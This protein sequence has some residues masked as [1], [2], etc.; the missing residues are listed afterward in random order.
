MAAASQVKDEI[1]GPVLSVGKF[2]TEEEAV[3]LANDT[4]Y[5]LAAGLHSSTCPPI[6][7]RPRR[8]VQMGV[9]TAPY[10]PLNLNTQ[11]CSAQALSPRLI[12]A[13]LPSAPPSSHQDQS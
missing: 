10:C 4:S 6:H 2:S 7:P 8:A 11:Q 5:G 12:V 1:F 13:H 3:K 9:R